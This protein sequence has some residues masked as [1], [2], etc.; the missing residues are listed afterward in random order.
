MIPV[1]VRAT[2]AQTPGR[3]ALKTVILTVLVAGAA[4]VQKEGLAL[5]LLLIFSGV[6]GPAIRIMTLRTS[7]IFDRIMVSPVNKPAVFLL[8]TGIWSTA[9]LSALVPAVAISLYLLGPALLVPIIT[10]SILAASIGTLSGL[11]ATTLGDAHLYAILATAPLVAGTLIPG[12]WSLVL[13]F[14]SLSMNTTSLL[15]S[16][17]QIGFL[18]LWLMITA[19]MASRM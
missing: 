13:P 10:G 19:G 4:L 2:A 7:G 14:S 6:T 12:P 15:F 9:V 16:L 5:A 1:P 8:Y 3:F 17:S 11:A 18:G